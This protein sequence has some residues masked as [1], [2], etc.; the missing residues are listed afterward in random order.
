MKFEL[1][2][3]YCDATQMIHVLTAELYESLHDNAGDPISDIHEVGRAI[4][5]FNTGVKAELGGI[6]NAADARS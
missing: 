6:F 4:D 5:K 2:K 1:S 3:E